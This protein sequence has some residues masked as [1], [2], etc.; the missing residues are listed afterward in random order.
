MSPDWFLKGLLRLSL[1]HYE[2]YLWSLM[3]PYKSELQLQRTVATRCFLCSIWWKS[4]INSTNNWNFRETWDYKL[5][6]VTWDQMAVVGR[7][8]HFL[9]TSFAVDSLFP[10]S[11]DLPCLIYLLFS[12]RFVVLNSVK[13]FVQSWLFWDSQQRRWKDIC[14]S[15]QF[16]PHSTSQIDPLHS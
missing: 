7:A 1:P 14:D 16:R 3:F 5:T 10:T 2:L 4:V 8:G 9:G 6:I 11:T 15:F 12:G 13:S